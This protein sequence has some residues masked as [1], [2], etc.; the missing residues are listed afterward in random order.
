M[1]DS[2]KAKCL[3]S[4]LLLR[5]EKAPIAPEDVMRAEK[6]KKKADKLLKK[7]I[8]HSPF[9]LPFSTLFTMARLITFRFSS[10]ST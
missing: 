5:T 2:S 3:F 1:S 8:G 9:P 6:E 4:H 7:V 10:I